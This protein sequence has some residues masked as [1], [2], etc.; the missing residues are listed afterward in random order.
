MRD[1]LCVSG[2]D[3]SGQHG[4]HPGLSQGLIFWVADGQGNSQVCLRQV[5]A[6]D[7][8]VELGH[9]SVL[10]GPA[11]DFGALWCQCQ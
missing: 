4:R 1:P 2:I 6:E 7:C 3:T 9:V 10:E 11:A 8:Q 5:S